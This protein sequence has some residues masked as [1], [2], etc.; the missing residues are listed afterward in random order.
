MSR[1]RMFGFV[2]GV[3]LCVLAGSTESQEVPFRRAIVDPDLSGDVIRIG[4]VG[5]GGRGNL[6]D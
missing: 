4:L 3:G 2:L 5:C 6:F 1:L